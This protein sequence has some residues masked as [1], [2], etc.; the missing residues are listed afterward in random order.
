MMTTMTYP[1]PATH[2]GEIE[3][4]LDPLIASTVRVLMENGVETFESCQGG[5]GHCY[6]EPTV[7]FFGDQ[8]AGFHALAVALR[9]G[10]GVSELRRVWPII[11]RE[12]TG[13]WWEMTFVPTT[14]G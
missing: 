3:S 5:P 8:S 13:P 2:L 14:D 11:D 1:D 10:L 4:T 6:P 12:P 9:Y 7:R